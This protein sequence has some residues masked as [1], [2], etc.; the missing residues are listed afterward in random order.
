VWQEGTEAAPQC[1]A[2]AVSDDGD[3][4]K[5]GDFSEEYVKAAERNFKREA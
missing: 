1:S 4:E 2:I 3:D 5:A